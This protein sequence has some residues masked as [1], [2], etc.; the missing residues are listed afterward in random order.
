MKTKDKI[1]KYYIRNSDGEHEY[2]IVSY[3]FDVICS[4]MITL[5][6]LIVVGYLL[7]CE[8]EIWIYLICHMLIAHNTGGYHATT[9]LRCLFFTTFTC[10][11]IIYISNKLWGYM[12]VEGVFISCVIYVLLVLKVAPVEHPNKKLEQSIMIASRKKSLVY[13]I[14][15]SSMIIVFWKINRRIACVLW[16]NVTEIIISMIIGKG[17]YH[18]DE[19]ESF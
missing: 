7:G 5:I 12:H 13:L 18:I 6:V 2:E 10:L 4:G 11:V 9:R 1:I 3:G 8:T 19:G 17:V 16:L 14:I 15:V